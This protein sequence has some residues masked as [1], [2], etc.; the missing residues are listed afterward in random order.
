MNS[1]VDLLLRHDLDDTRHLID[2]AKQLD[3]DDYRA[4]RRRGR[5]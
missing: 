3:D 4:H 1:L 5:S 2:K